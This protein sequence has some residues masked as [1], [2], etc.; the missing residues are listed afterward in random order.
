MKKITLK[1]Y[2]ETVGQSA[3]AL[4]LGVKQSAISKA[5]RLKRD[6]TVQI[7]LD[8]TVSAHEVKPFPNF[9]KDLFPRTG[10]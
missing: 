3:A 7:H 9:K 5:I 8:G 4:A 10:G 6:V 1:D 2:A